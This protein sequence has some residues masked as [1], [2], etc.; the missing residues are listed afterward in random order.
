MG[1]FIHRK[2]KMEKEGIKYQEPFRIGNAYL[3]FHVP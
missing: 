1:W 2:N 3:T